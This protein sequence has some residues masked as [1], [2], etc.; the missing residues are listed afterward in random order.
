MER[1][2]A[3]VNSVSEYGIVTAYIG[4]NKIKIV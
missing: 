3:L 2:F 4:W 1:Y